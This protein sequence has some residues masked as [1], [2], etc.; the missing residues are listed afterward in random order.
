MGL[1]F[2]SQKTYKGYTLV[3][4]FPSADLVSSITTKYLIEKLKM[5]YLGHFDHENTTPIVKIEN[6][7]PQQPIR[8]YASHKHK[9]ICIISDQVIQKEDLKSYCNIVLNW[10]KKAKMA[11]IV[12][13]GG[14]IDN[15]NGAVYGVANNKKNLEYL[16]TYKIQKIKEGITA[17]IGAQFFILEKEFPIY[18][19][20]VPFTARKN[21][22]AAAKAIVVLNKMYDLNIDTKPLLEES[23]ELG[24][25]VSDQLKESKEKE[26]NGPNII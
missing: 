2:K 4:G 19:I 26:Y 7:L 11:R 24:N 21:Y 15:K 18:L 9:L 5:E 13:I 8:A 10:A 17:G 6:G 20:L 1:F 14:I 25:A 12:S 22:D 16:D 23:K 3:E